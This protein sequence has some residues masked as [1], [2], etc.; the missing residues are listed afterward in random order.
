M[1]AIDTRPVWTFEDA[2]KLYKDRFG[3][4]PIVSG[5][6]FEESLPIIDILEAVELGVEIKGAPM[7]SGIVS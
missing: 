6:D 3:D 7:P 4:Y 1:T 2:I 5:R